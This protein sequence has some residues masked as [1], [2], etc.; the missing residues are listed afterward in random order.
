MH[1]CSFAFRNNFEEVVTDP[2]MFFHLIERYFQLTIST[3][4]T[5]NFSEQ[6]GQLVLVQVREGDHFPT[7]SV[8]TLMPHLLNDPGGEQGGGVAKGD[9]A[10]GTLW[11]PNQ[12][13][14]SDPVFACAANE[15]TIAADR[16]RA[17]LARH[18]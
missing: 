13:L 4:W 16:Y 15:V 8:L 17:P 12:R 7:A 1:L 3:V 18:Q 11:L 14:L 6:A 9:H 10:G 5:S 2:D